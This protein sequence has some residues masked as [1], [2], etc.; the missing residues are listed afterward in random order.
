MSAEHPNRLG[1]HLHPSAGADPLA[2]TTANAAVYA[3]DAEAVEICLFDRGPGHR[4]VEERRVRL[5]RRLHGTFYGEVPDVR[6][7]QRYGLRVY[8]P[9]DPG[10]GLRLN[11]AKLLLDPYAK[12]ITGSIVW[13]QAVFGHSVDRVWQPVDGP[14]QFGG[15]RVMD[16]TDSFGS[17]P[18]GVILPELPPAKRGPR[19]PWQRTVIYEAHVKGLTARHPALPPEQRG[20]WAGLAH[21]AVI[22]HLTKLG[23]TAVELLPVFARG[24]EPHLVR[25]GLHNYWGYNHLSFFAPEP[26]YVTAAARAKGPAAVIAEIVS[27]IETLH[28]AG[29]EVLLDVVYNHSCEGGPDGPTLSW[30]GL[31][32]RSYYR[33][34]DLGR[35]IDFT[36]TGNTFDFSKA[37][38]VRLTLDSLRHWVTAYGIDGFRFDLAPALARGDAHRSRD[39]YDPDH[40]LLVAMR[41]DPILNEVKLIAEPWDVGPNGWHTGEFPPPFAEWN[42]R[43]RDVVRGFWIADRGTLQAGGGP[44]RTHLSELATRLAGSSDHFGRA[45]SS[46]HLERPAWAS[47]NFV[48]AHDGFAL[49]DLV[50]FDHKHNEANGEDNRDGTN[51]NLSWNHGVEGRTSQLDVQAARHRTQLATLSTLLLSIGTPMLLAGDELGR[52]QDGNNNAYCQDNTTTWVNWELTSDRRASAPMR[53]ANLEAVRELLR[54]RASHPAYTAP[55]RPDGRTVD[56]HGATDVGWF[57]PDGRPMTA[58]HWAD[59]SQRTLQMAL[60]GGPSGAYTVLVVVHGGDD[61]I[62]L[63][64]PAAPWA[65]QWTKEWDSAEFAA[66]TWGLDP[67][68]ERPVLEAGATTKLVGC[69]VALFLGSPPTTGHLPRGHVQ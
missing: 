12:A 40:P 56:P 60:H 13:G 30:Q 31:G 17:V 24:D 25:Q 14:S 35:N 7:G 52:T 5:D 46:D 66:S 58:E 62:E 3:P 34:D 49:A 16:Y 43:Y 33:T 61:P 18:L 39:G 10:R 26:S 2:T 48:T 57:S 15:G 41:T 68:T 32:G 37:A 47:I 67:G 28:R 63:T 64:L 65:S 59:T 29:L 27:A 69:T 1:L 21:P 45:T 38:V 44:L 8:G 11:P 55:E 54:L 53:R 51:N 19:T 36:G 6:P 42:D 22:E 50:A 4:A 23:V 20:T 9:W